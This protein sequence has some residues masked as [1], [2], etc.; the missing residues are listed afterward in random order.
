MAAMTMYSQGEASVVVSGIANVVVSGLATPGL[1][2]HS[3]SSMSPG[4]GVVGAGGGVFINNNKASL[5]VGDLDSY[6]D[7][8][9]LF[10]LFN[11]VTEVASVKICRDQTKHS[12]LGYGYV[13]FNNERDAANA[14]EVLNFTLLNGKPIRIMFSHRDPTIRKTGFAN[15]FI[16]NL[17]ASIDNKA[18]RDTFSVFGRILSCK[19]V[20]DSNGKSKGYGFVHYNNEESAQAAIGKLNGM[21]L[22]DKQVYVGLFLRRQDRIKTSGSPSVPKFTNIYVKNL[23]KTTTVEDLQEMFGKYGGITSAVVM[24]DGS[25]KSKGF[26]FINFEKPE[27]AVSAVENMNGTS[28]SDK[29][30]YVGKAQRKTE[31]EAELKDKFE[32]ERIARFEKLKGANLY[33]KNLD[34]GIT[35]EK[36]K[37][38]FSRFGTITSCKVL[39]DSQG[40]TK[41]AGFVA[42]SS[43][44]EA[45]IAL[46]EMKGKMIGKK[47]LY[48]AIAQRKDERRAKLQAYFA[49]V[50]VPSGVAPM[51]MQ[52][53]VQMPLHARTPGGFHPRVP[54]PNYYHLGQAAAAP[55]LIQ[56]LPPHQGYGYQH[57][58][59][60]GVVR[61]GGG[62][63][64]PYQFQRHSPSAAPVH[65]FGDGRRGGNFNHQQQ[66]QQHNSNPGLRRY[67][68]NNGLQQSGTDMP[69]LATTVASASSENQ[70]LILG[71]Q[72]FPLVEPLVQ[73]H[74]SKITG[75]LLEMDQNELLHLIES[76]DAL[77]D[78]AAEAMEVLRLSS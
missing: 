40:L 26:G 29:V 30:L 78:K 7:D 59:L 18:L 71:E 54:P 48:V 19:V 5:Y 39:V 49:Q 13:N 24:T 36:L 50:R 1:A 34:D 72:L 35:D 2:P 57:Q 55:G 31:R 47:P 75:M 38:L 20:M 11:Q 44:E 8:K 52:M 6:V 62:Y 15:V 43:P 23:P 53:P 33:M 73:E 70:R 65:R 10:D 37:D 25:G 61:T 12:S 4:V 66:H 56:P 68:V 27:D 60:P 32:Q 51:P 77:K 17:D 45:S 28:L 46:K 21:L 63:V 69:E 74:A 22:N 14:M 3:S 67:V 16:K 58:L 41:G 64:M 76:P 9:Q 42:F